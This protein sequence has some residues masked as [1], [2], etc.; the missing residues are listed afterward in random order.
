M[1]KHIDKVLEY[2]AETTDPQEEAVS[3]IKEMRSDILGLI[4]ATDVVEVDGRWEDGYWCIRESDSDE[5]D[6]LIEGLRRKY[7]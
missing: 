4:N 7:G 1:S 3:L 6:E 2:L 5:I